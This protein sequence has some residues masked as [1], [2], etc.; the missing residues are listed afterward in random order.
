[1]TTLGEGTPEPDPRPGRDRAGGIEETGE[2]ATKTL[3]G[4]G[5]VAEGTCDMTDSDD[6]V[7]AESGEKEEEEGDAVDGV[8][9]EDTPDV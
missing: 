6:D 2:D 9:T 4:T 3:G 8:A 7:E 5:E 1:M